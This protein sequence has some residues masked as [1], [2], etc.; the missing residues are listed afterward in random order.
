MM[1]FSRRGYE[2]DW[3]LHILDEEAMLPY[4]RSAGC[5]NYARYAAFYVH[6]MKGLD[7][8][9]MKI[10][11]CGVFE[12]HISG[13]CNSTWTDMFIETTYLRLWHGPTG[14]IGWLQTTIIMVN[15]ALSF[16]LSGHVS[17]CS[18]VNPFVSWFFLIRRLQGLGF[19]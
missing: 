4:F 5:H 13:I 1:N 2:R 18:I 10:L 3:V 14:D 17:Q 11:Q 16:A 6:H 19:F 8:V 12:R 7:Q 9:I 15:W